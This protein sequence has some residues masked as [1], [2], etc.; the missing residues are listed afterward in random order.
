MTRRTSTGYPE[1]TQEQEPLGIDR[2]F[3]VSLLLMLGAS[4]VTLTSTGKLDIVSVV[5]ISLALAVRLWGYG[6][7][8]NL[9]LSARMA[10]HLATGYIF[11]FILDFFILSAGLSPLDSMLNATVHLVLFT[12]VVK[13]FSAHTH[14]DYAYLAALSFL[15]MLASAVLTVNTA[16][17]VFLSFY[18]LFAISTFTSYEIKRS[19]EASSRRAGAP[20]PFLPGNRATIERS[21][22]KTSTGLALGTVSLASILFFVI[23]RYRSGW[24]SPGLFGSAGRMRLLEGR[25]GRGGFLHHG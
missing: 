23:P 10:T 24:C 13:V 8:L 6:R 9:R 20:L 5:I 19:L 12:A 17:L 22:I 14:R 15:I 11:F 4:F 2:Y 16:Y 7:N 18:V 1:L 21:L 3:E 25:R